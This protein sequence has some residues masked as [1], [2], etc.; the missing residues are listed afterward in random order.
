M[1]QCSDRSPLIMKYFDNVCD[2]AK[3]AYSSRVELNDGLWDRG[4]M[5]VA[6]PP[7]VIIVVALLSLNAEFVVA[8]GVA[9]DSG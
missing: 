9:D 4:C 8:L 1:S 2:L 6:Q 3:L 7:I 5:L